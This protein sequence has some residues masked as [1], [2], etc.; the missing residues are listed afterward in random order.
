MAVSPDGSV[1]ALGTERGDARVV[2]LLQDGE[3]RVIPVP[4][5]GR[6]SDLAFN[7]DGRWLAVAGTKTQLRAATG[8]DVVVLIETASGAEVF[9]DP[10]QGGRLNTVAFADAGTRFVAANGSGQVLLYDAAT[11]ARL[12]RFKGDD[13]STMRSGRS[14]RVPVR[15]AVLSPDGRRVYAAG[16]EAGADTGRLAEWDAETGERVRITDLSGVPS[17]LVRSPDGRTL[18]IGFRAGG[19]EAWATGWGGAEQALAEDLA[20]AGERDLRKLDRIENDREKVL[21]AERWLAEHTVSHRLASRVEAMRA[22]ARLGYPALVFDGPARAEFLAQQLY[23]IEVTA[24]ETR[25]AP[26]SLTGGAHSPPVML[27][28]AVAATLR[29]RDGVSLLLA[30]GRPTKIHRFNAPGTLTSDV[31]TQ[32]AVSVLAESP[33]GKALAMSGQWDDGRHWLVV[34]EAFGGKVIRVTRLEGVDRVNTLAYSPDGSRLVLGTGNSHMDLRLPSAK[35]P[36]ALLI[37]D[38]V[39]GE[40]YHRLQVVGRPNFVLFTGAGQAFVVGDNNDRLTVYD[41]ASG[42]KLREFSSKETGHGTSGEPLRV[43]A[44][45]APIRDG[46]LSKDGSKLTAVSGKPDGTEGELTVWDV[47]GGERLRVV[48][49]LKSPQSI[50]LSPDGLWYAIGYRDRVELWPAR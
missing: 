21:A 27:P 44:A 2:I 31:W 33:N 5:V 12:R 10:R 25:I 3:E 49:G 15:G 47:A 39:T 37:L 30:G 35:I 4:R 48:R 1:L 7:S 22:E 26:R 20:R 13:E 18:L 9:R 28:F 19:L 6:I 32:G 16:G 24:R 29:A 17:Q 45:R 23:T 36:N 42:R 46:V 50:R 34:L 41:A 14:M 43:T 38:P 40:E 11:A 8:E